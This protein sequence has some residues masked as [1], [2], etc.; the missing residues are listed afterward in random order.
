[1]AFAIHASSA[2]T[3]ETLR[4][5]DRGRLTPGYFADVIIFDQQ[6]IADK[7]TYEQPKLLPAGMKY[8]IVNGKVAI[9]DGKFTGTLAG[10][11]V[12]RI[13]TVH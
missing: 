8:V 1:M 6:T 4:I 13:A 5:A 10:R 12:K 7:S 3:A 11:P 9:D 2:L